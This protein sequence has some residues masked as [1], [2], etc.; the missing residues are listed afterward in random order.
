VAVDPTRL[1]QHGVSY[2][3]VGAAL[4]AANLNL[5]GGRIQEN[6]REWV[7][8]T[9]GELGRISEIGQVVVHASEAG[10]V[11]LEDVATV[12]DG[13]KETRKLARLNQEPSIALSIQRESSG[14]TVA[15]S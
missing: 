3:Q 12:I 5:P 15:A 9:V 1:E 10:V 7:V 8:R 11:R 2:D 4:A 6:G 14:N 13:F